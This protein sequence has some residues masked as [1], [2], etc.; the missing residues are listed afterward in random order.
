MST[1]STNL[2]YGRRQDGS[3]N[4]LF[5]GLGRMAC[6]FP[7]VHDGSSGSHDTRR[8]SPTTVETMEA[9]ARLWCAAPELLASLEAISDWCRSNLSPV[10]VPDSSC[11]QLLCDAVGTIAKAKGIQP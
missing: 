4:A 11:H 1:H 10:L 9:N 6:S 3:P 5:D 8:G 2:T 7:A